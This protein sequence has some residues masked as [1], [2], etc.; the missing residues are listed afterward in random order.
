MKSDVLGVDKAAI[1]ANGAVSEEVAKAMAIGALKQLNVD[2]ALSVTGIAGPSGG[3]AQ[4]PVGTIWLGL[5]QIQGEHIEV[6]TH[7]LDLGDIGRNRIRDV[8][9]LEALKLFDQTLSAT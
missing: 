6:F 2:M 7:R 4:K 9:V 3:T 5:A 1:E 8:S